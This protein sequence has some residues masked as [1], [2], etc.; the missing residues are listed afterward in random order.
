MC[1]EVRNV[2]VC[3]CVCVRARVLVWGAGYNGVCV[4]ACMLM[5]SLCVCVC[6]CVC[7]SHVFARTTLGAF[8]GMVVSFFAFLASLSASWTTLPGKCVCE[9]VNA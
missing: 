2:C 3:V 1:E 5:L 8:G 4:H 9:C 7:V 6:V